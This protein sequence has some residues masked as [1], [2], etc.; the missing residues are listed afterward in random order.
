MVGNGKLGKQPTK[1]A[2][3]L[4]AS[5]GNTGISAS[6]AKTSATPAGTG[7]NAA[8]VASDTRAERSC[9][10]ALALTGAAFL[11]LV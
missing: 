10:A 4:R 3:A 8:A 7:V 11:L 2:V 9:V 6:K 5:S 1:K